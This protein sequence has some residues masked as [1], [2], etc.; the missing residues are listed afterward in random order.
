MRTLRSLR[1]RLPICIAMIALACSEARPFSFHGGLSRQFGSEKFS[2]SRWRADGEEARGKMVNSLMH[3]YFPYAGTEE[4]IISLLGP[5]E[6][7]GDDGNLCYRF[8]SK[9]RSY[10]LEFL[11][12]RST[13][14]PRVVGAGIGEA[15]RE[16][17]S[18]MVR[19]FPVPANTR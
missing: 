17:H 4:R 19:S 7:H 5:S 1:V 10:Q 15:D 12:D 11:V 3:S 9:K 2:S 14:P 13:Q 16:V 6:C 8:T 18:I